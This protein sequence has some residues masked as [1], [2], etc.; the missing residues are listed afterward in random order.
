LQESK[1]KILPY[2][3]P[4]YPI[5]HTHFFPNRNLLT[6]YNLKS[7]KG[8]IYNPPPQRINKEL[9]KDVHHTKVEFLFS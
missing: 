2:F 3:P 9:K 1:Y 6:T 7:Y 8:M 4:L 5:S